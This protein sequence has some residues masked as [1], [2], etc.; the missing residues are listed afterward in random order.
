[1]LSSSGP[2]LVVAHRFLQTSRMGTHQNCPSTLQEDSTTLH[3]WIESH[4]NS[5][6]ARVQ[7]KFGAHLPYL[8]KVTTYVFFWRFFE[9]AC[10][11]PTIL[12]ATWRPIAP[13]YLQILSV[14]KALSIQSHPD[15]NLAEQLHKQHPKVRIRIWR[16]SHSFI[17]ELIVWSWIDP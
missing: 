16:W 2:C 17:K 10:C 11:L 3:S 13:C 8:L 14:K 9:L 4:P 5:L 15:K 7:M 1:M 12:W 6:G